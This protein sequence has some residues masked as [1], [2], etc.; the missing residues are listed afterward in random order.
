MAT[1]A[2]LKEYLDLAVKHGLT[3]DSALKYASEQ[4]DRADRV[5]I[6]QE[7]REEKARQEEKEREERARQEER[8]DKARQAEEARRERREEKEREE[9][10][11]L[12]QHELEMERLRL[13]R[14]EIDSSRGSAGES[15][16]SNGSAP[17][18][19][20]AKRPKLPAFVDGK[21]DLDS[22]LNRFERLA[23]A[24]GWEEA[25]W[26]VNI[27]ALLSGRALEVYTRLN[28]DDANDYTKLKEALLQRYGLTGEGYRMRMRDAKPEPDESP[29]QFIHRLTSYLKKWITLTD[30]EHS[31]EGLQNLIIHEQFMNICPRQLTI[32]LREKATYCLADLAE[33]AQKFLEAHDRSLSSLHRN[34]VRA[35]I[36]RNLSAETEA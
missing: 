32:Y 9:R 28:E 7:E 13:E 8:E 16:N 23:K 19:P 12:R 26:A 34:V 31:F 11:Q 36:V 35:N 21:D 10:E 14:A 24:N 33:H 25:D 30:T 2:G 6:R 17:A 5:R 3:G 1:L 20:N 27:S 4:L 18:L 29:Q 15:H 22:Y